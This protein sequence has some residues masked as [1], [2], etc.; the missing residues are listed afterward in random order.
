MR[1]EFT[2][3]ASLPRLAWCLRADERDTI[4][5]VVHGPWVET[6]ED[7]L[8]EGAWPGLFADGRIGDGGVL[9]GSG[10]MLR[11]GRL[12]VHAPSQT[13]EAVYSVRAGRSL[14]FSNSVPFLSSAS[15]SAL[16]PAYRDYEDDALSITDGL[17]RY[18]RDV[19]LRDGRSLGVHYFCDVTVEPDLTLRST[20]KTIDAPGFSSF[21]EYRAFL[22]SMVA[23]IAENARDPARK[24]RFEPIAFC[25]TGYDSTACAALGRDIGCNEAV[26]F[27]SRRGV[28]SDSGRPIAEALGY[29]R[30]VERH[31]RDYLA[32]P[33]SADFLGTGELATSI[34]FAAA[35]EEL[36]GKLLLSGSHGDRIWG[37]ELADNPHLVRFDYTDGART[38]FRL[39]TGY[40]NF[41]VPF[42]G[43]QRHADIHRIS[44]SEEMAPWRLGNSYD[45]PIPRRIAEEA[46]APRELFGTYKFGGVGN[47]LRFGGLRQLGRIMN[48]QDFA[49]FRSFY[50]G[51]RRN[52][53]LLRSLFYFL[54]CGSIVVQGLGVTWPRRFLSRAP[55]RWRCSPWAPSYLFLWAAQKLAARYESG[56]RLL[57]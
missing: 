13:T 44:R 24:R 49:E 22:G 57:R 45:R 29:R 52:P 38:E 15:G 14:F 27:E 48:P 16:D 51:Q 32:L 7:F 53:G 23:G 41:P 25:S 56:A 54:Y 34:Y 20:T 18:R 30:I 11:D 5:R 26:A 39:R 10:A 35:A 1:F 46:G 55:R 50:R 28:R 6:G 8:V 47:S 42:V 19:P 9:M 4:V 36:E 17:Q 12:V 21:G 37:L 43:L 3:V 40:L 31:E 33:V 2:E